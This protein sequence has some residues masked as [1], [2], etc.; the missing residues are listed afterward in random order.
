M[1]RLFVKTIAIATVSLFALTGCG[2]GGNNWGVDHQGSEVEIAHGPL[3]KD[4]RYRCDFDKGDAT[5]VKP[6]EL[7]K[8][9]TKDTEIRTWHF[10]NSQE[11]ICT[12]KG[13]AVIAKGK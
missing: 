6:G 11:Y 2:G 9:K 1:N 3:Q 12:L 8:P 4:G 10:Q 5:L 7:V 13:K